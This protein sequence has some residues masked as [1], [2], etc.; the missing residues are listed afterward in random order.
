[1]G[2]FAANE[3]SSGFDFQNT[4]QDEFGDRLIAIFPKRCLRKAW[5]RARQLEREEKQSDVSRDRLDVQS[6]CAGAENAVKVGVIGQ[7]A[8]RVLLDTM[9]SVEEDNLLSGI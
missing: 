1:M 3:R 4:V 9:K 5:E 6:G 2:V 8:K 7:F